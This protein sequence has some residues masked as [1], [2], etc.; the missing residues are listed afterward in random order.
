MYPT[1]QRRN[2]TEAGG[3][4]ALPKMSGKLKKFLQCS[5]KVYV[6]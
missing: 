6:T 1:Q 5:V 2:Q 4:A 3:N